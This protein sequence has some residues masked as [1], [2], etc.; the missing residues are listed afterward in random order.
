MWK[1]LGNGKSSAMRLMSQLMKFKLDLQCNAVSLQSTKQHFVLQSVCSISLHKYFCQYFIVPITWNKHN[2]KEVYAGTADYKSST[3]VH[4][5]H[6][7][8][9]KLLIGLSRLKS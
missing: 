3:I 2:S 4:N 5:A 9:L 7:I 8:L 1:K 6:A